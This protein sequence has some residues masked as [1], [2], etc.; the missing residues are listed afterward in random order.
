MTG[1]PARRAASIAGRCGG[2]PGLSTTRSAPVS[3]DAWCP[4]SSSATPAARRRSSSVDLLADVGQRD[5]G[6]AAHQQL[7]GGH[8]AA[9]RAD[10]DDPLATNG[11]RRVAHLQLQRRQAEER[12]DDRE[13]QEPRDHLRLAPADQLEVVMNR[14][15]AEDALAGDLERGDLDDDR[16]RLHHEHAADDREQRLLLDEERDGAERAAEP[17]RSDVAHEDLGRVRSCTRGSARLAP[18]SAPQKIVSSEAAGG[19][20]VSC[21]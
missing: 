10:D 2:T 3:V 16:H 19:T 14:R 12:E 9:G 20:G 4:P 17:E 21:R 5:A 13:D 18:T 7:R 6:A 11:E 1:T 8:T 15:H